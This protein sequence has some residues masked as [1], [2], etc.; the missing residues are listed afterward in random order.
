MWNYGATQVDAGTLAIMNNMFVPVGLLVNFVVW[1]QHP[2]WFSFI[3][4]GSSFAGVHGAITLAGVLSIGVISYRWY[5]FSGSLSV[6][7]YCNWG[8]H[9]LDFYWRACFVAFIA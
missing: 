9:A 3:L 4:G 7:F 5:S 8:D 2:D 6:S 1:Q